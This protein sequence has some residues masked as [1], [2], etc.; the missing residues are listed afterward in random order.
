MKKSV[1]I[2]LCL[3][4][5]L[6]SVPMLL[7]ADTSEL[8]PIMGDAALSPEAMYLYLVNWRAE[9][10]EPI[11]ESYAREF[12][13]CV[14][15]EAQSEGVRH[16]AAFA[17]MMHETGFLCFG[18]DVSVS[19]NNF[20]GIGATGNGAAGAEFAD[21]QTGIR[22]VV[23]HLKCYASEEALSGECVDPRFADYLRN[24]SP[25]IEWLGRDDNPN[26]F[27]WA[28][29]GAGYGARLLEMIEE[30]KLLDTAEIPPIPIASE[31][32][33]ASGSAVLSAIGQGG[34]LNFALA[35]VLFA[36]ILLIWRSRR[37]T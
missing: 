35:A 6:A 14:V 13:A 34:A 11:D 15:R 24:K 10:G 30:M 21:M 37:R 20:G 28:V 19:Q 22:A 4:L 32:E 16:D 7:G 17:L 5:I 2:N 12:V 18:G 1:K 33:E 23:Q 29:P 3:I 26:G 8:N 31:G 9:R 36:L 27:G 25:Y